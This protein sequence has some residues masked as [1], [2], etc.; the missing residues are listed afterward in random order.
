MGPPCRYI[1]SPLVRLVL[2]CWR[3]KKIAYLS[4]DDADGLGVRAHV[5]ERADGSRLDL[6]VIGP[7]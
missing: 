5:V 2:V 3:D 7:S 4:A 6:K 1:P